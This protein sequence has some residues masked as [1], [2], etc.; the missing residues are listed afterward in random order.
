MKVT[1]LA[2]VFSV[3]LSLCRKMTYPKAEMRL[4]YASELAQ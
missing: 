2:S 4:G 1:L 3:S